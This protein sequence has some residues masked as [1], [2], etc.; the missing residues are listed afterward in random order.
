MIS[1]LLK[2]LGW[3]V[4]T[5]WVVFTVSFALMRSVPGGPFSSDR[6]L[7]KEVERSVKARYNL[8][9]PLYIQYLNMLA[10]YATLDFGDSFRL[11]DFSVNR[12]I[13]EGFP[14]SA[15]LG[16]FALA[17]ALCVGVPCGAIAAV[18]RRGATDVG[19]MAAA[20]VGIAVPNFVFAGVSIL[21]FSFYWKFF[22]PAGWG[23]LE[24]LVL[25]SIC[26][27]LPYAA[28]IA[29]L[30]RTGMLDVLG[31]DYI[32]TARAKGLSETWIVMRHAAPGAMLPVVSFLGPAVANI[33]S[34][35]LVVERVFALPGLGSHFLEAA[36]QRDYTLA[37]GMIVVYTV[38]LYVMNLIVDLSY[39][40][41]NPRVKLD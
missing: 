17:F 11:Q 29:R 26:L 20:T 18:Y 10:D 27:G 7:S 16:L 34:G 32:R 35:S 36:F 12:I 15:A 41:I 21:L 3:F 38:L 30:T 28:Y 2:R 37:M 22:P 1:F 40:W 8:D 9:D 31:Q 23:S 24:Q 39:G 33:L 14:I 19:L 6:Q 13:A 25:P 5:V 4:L